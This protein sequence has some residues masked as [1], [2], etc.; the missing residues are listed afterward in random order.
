MLF[1]EDISTASV[2]FIARIITFR[3]HG[4]VDMGDL[5]A[6]TLERLFVK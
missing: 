4:L 2:D 3:D 5:Q 1:I 6:T